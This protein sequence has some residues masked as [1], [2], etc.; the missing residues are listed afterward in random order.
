MVIT[1]IPRRKRCFAY[2]VV[3]LVELVELLYVRLVVASSR[4]MKEQEN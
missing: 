3:E 4:A 1:K 2:S